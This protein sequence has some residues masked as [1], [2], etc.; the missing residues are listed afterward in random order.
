M[1]HAGDYRIELLLDESFI[2][3]GEVSGEG[4][5]TP[6]GRGRLAGSLWTNLAVSEAGRSLEFANFELFSEDFT[7]TLNSGP[8]PLGTVPVEDAFSFSATRFRADLSPEPGAT[9]FIVLPGRMQLGVRAK[10]AKSSG[11]ALLLNEGAVTRLLQSGRPLVHP[12]RAGAGF[13]GQGD[14][15]APAWPGGQ[16]SP[17]G[18]ARARP[19][20]RMHLAQGHSRGPRWPRLD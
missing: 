10:V 15:P 1:A 9:D 5:F 14:A 3:V 8:V 11:G 20:R 16:R 6:L 12:G 13:R 17:G 18:P 19:G 4:D 2:E 7:V